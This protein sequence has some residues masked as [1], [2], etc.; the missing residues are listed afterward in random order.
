MAR[1]LPFLPT[2]LQGAV[3]LGKGKNKTNAFSLSISQRGSPVEMPGMPCCFL[4]QQT[5]EGCIPCVCFPF[6]KLQVTSGLAFAWS[7]QMGSSHSLKVAGWKKYKG[8]KKWKR[9]EIKEKDRKAFKIGDK[10]IWTAGMISVSANHLAR[11]QPTTSGTESHLEAAKQSRTVK[12]KLPDV[13]KKIHTQFNLP[14]RDSMV[15]TFFYPD[16][17]KWAL[18]KPFMLYSFKIHFYYLL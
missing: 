9:I 3:R 16:F 10:E 17:Y 12:R 1:C 11:P 18:G 2:L 6:S 7:E 13:A 5:A 4:H 15:C 8:K 14:F